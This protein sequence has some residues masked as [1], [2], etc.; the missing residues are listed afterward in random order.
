MRI[1]AQRLSILSVLLL[2]ACANVQPFMPDKPGPPIPPGR[3]CE[4]EAC[5]DIA[6][7]V[8]EKCPPP[9]AIETVEFRGGMGPRRLRW[10]ITGPWEFSQD[11][12]SPAI[13]FTVKNG[14]SLPG[15]RMGQP[16]FSGGNKV[17]DVVWQRRGGNLNAEYVLNLKNPQGVLCTIDPWIVDK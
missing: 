11:P 7:N 4:G 1:A 12:H 6:V 13:F 17:M 5:A 16:S 10:V 15:G 2:A 3:P 8:S 9:A 14:G